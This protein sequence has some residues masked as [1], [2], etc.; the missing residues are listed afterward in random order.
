VYRGLVALLRSWDW[1]VISSYKHSAPPELR[2][3]VA[4]RTRC[5][6]VVNVFSNIFTTETQRFFTEA[7][8]IAFFRKTPQPGSLSFFRSVLIRVHPRLIFSDAKNQL[9]QAKCRKSSRLQMSKMQRVDNSEEETV[10]VIQAD[11]SDR[12]SELMNKTE[13]EKEWI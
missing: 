1:V 5:A 7:Q 4:A 6:S 9:P 11:Q 10:R 13:L 3:F 12:Q 8:R 2:R